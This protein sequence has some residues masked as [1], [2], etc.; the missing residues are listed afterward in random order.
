MKKYLIIA[1]LMAQGFA[2]DTESSEEGDE[3]VSHLLEGAMD[4]GGED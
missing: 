3:V 1:F 2:E 4:L